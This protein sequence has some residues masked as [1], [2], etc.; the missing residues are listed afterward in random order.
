MTTAYILICR[1]L[2][3]QWRVKNE[4]SGGIFPASSASAS[5]AV[6]FTAR[7]ELIM[8][9][10]ANVTANDNFRNSYIIRSL[11]VFMQR[12]FGIPRWRSE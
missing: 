12:E 1:K 5:H 2:K 9:S 10:L 3:R 6:V 11:E 7:Q 4:L 8:G